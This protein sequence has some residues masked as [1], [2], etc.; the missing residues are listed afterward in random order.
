[1]AWILGLTSGPHDSGACLLRDGALICA[2]NEERF[3]RRKHDGCFPKRSIE[4]CLQSQNIAPN[5]ISIVAHG[6]KFDG[7]DLTKRLAA[8]PVEVQKH[9]R[10]MAAKFRDVDLNVEARLRSGLQALGIPE[11]RLQMYDHHSCHAAAAFFAWP[12]RLTANCCDCCCVTLDGRGDYASGKIVN[13]CKKPAVLDV[14]SMF[15]S[16]GMLW[17]FVT[18]SLGFKAFRHEGKLTGLAAHGDGSRTARIFETVMGLV[19]DGGLWRIRAF[20]QEE[21]TKNFMLFLAS[22]E[23]PSAERREVR[24]FALYQE[25]QQHQPK[26]VAA[27]LQIFTEDLLLDYMRL[28]NFVKPYICVAGGVFANVRLNLRLRQRFQDVT[29]V[30]VYPNMGD[31]G[32][33]FGAAAL[34]ASDAGQQ[35]SCPKGSVFLGPDFSAELGDVLRPVSVFGGSE[36]SHLEGFAEEVAAYLARGKVVGLYVGAMEFGPRALGNRSLLASATDPAINSDLNARLGRTEYMPFAPMTLRSFAG[37]AYSDFPVED[38]EAGRH[39]TMCYEATPELKK[40]CP[41]VV[42]V[43]NTVRPQVVDER[44]GLAYHV[45]V[46][47]E[48]KTGMHSL[49]NTSFNMHEDPIVCTPK[50]AM[51]AFEKGACDVLAAFPFLIWMTMSAGDGASSGYVEEQKGKPDA[52]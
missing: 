45:L 10:W 44:D 26:D 19:E 12:A 28:N 5:D 32:L 29:Q 52:K 4:Y 40:M 14:T 33:C 24:T 3:S 36:I 34:A 7:Q 8:E 21:E 46:H 27:G 51:H 18:A 15:D 16:L 17:A 13:F 11:A 48:A 35:V 23:G 20:W 9:M 38:L 39:M 43:D 49:I 6:W 2:A 42:H 41:A 47:Y 50:D 22:L 1:M 37:Q 30:F 31:A 25:L